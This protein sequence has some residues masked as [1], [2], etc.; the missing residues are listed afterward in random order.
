V[1]LV[2]EQPRLHQLGLALHLPKYLKYW[3]TL[4]SPALKVAVPF[5]KFAYA[6]LQSLRNH[7]RNLEIDQL[8]SRDH[9][10]VVKLEFFLQDHHVPVAVRKNCP[11]AC[12]NSLKTAISSFPH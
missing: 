12:L 7:D 4:S 10:F 1:V 8:K 9:R 6:A 2:P 11:P 5:Q 3:A